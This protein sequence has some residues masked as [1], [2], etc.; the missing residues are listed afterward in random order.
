MLRTDQIMDSLKSGLSDAILKVDKPQENR[1]LVDVECARIR[2]VSNRIIE[3][4]GRYQVS[5]GYDNIERD[6]TMGMIH[7]FVFDK[8][9]FFLN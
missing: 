3:I 5:I 6:G 4:G 2:E 1:V 8:D 9:N 7:A